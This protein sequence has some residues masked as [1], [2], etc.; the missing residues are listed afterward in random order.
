MNLPHAD[1][2]PMNLDLTSVDHMNP[3]LTG[4]DLTGVDL[5]GVDLTNLSFMNPVRM[6][7]SGIMGVSGTHP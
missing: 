4:L 2:G 3:G 6:A 5:T 7:A 1:L